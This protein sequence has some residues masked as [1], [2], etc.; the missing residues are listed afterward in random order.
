MSE[1]SR[2][3]SQG[4]EGVIRR[5]TPEENRRL[6]VAALREHRC[7][8]ARQAGWNLAVE[9]VIEYVQDFTRT[10]GVHPGPALIARQ[11]GCPLHPEAIDR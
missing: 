6:V 4:G 1:Q 3:V 9:E 7:D 8:V 10:N 2:R 5:V 11:M